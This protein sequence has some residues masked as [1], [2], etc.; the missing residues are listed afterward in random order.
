[1]AIWAYVGG[2]EHFGRP[3]NHVWPI[4]LGIGGH[5]ANSMMVG[6]V[7]VAVLAALRPRNDLT[8]I[9]LGVAYALG[10]WSL[11]RYVLLPLNGGEDDLF[12]TNLVSPQWVWWVA[13]AALGMTAGIVY[14]VVRR[15][16]TRP[17][18]RRE[19]ELLRAA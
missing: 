4:L 14:D 19:E 1:M 2:L 5:M 18:P 13:H 11:M 8:P 3:A 12:T 9:M 7:F 15:L 16:G 10:L 17:H 6:V